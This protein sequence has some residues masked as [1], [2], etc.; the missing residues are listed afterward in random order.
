MI[1]LSWLIEAR[2]GLPAERMD[3]IGKDPNQ[4]QTVVNVANRMVNYWLS[5]VGA[6]LTAER[7][8]RYDLGQVWDDRVLRHAAA[9][10]GGVPRVEIADPERSLPGALQERLTAHIALPPA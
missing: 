8:P 10:F 3:G 4:S 1:S 7:L 2:A 5:G 9:A 6:A